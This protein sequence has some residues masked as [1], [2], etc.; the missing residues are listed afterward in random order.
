MKPLV[1]PIVSQLDM[2]VEDE[3]NNKRLIQ[4]SESNFGVFLGR[5]PKRGRA[6]GSRFFMLHMCNN[7]KRASTKP[8]S[9]T[10]QV[11]PINKSV[12]FNIN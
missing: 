10:Q 1:E 7:I 12:I 8:Q 11:T 2:Q 9:L 3:T 5:Y 6:F 4:D